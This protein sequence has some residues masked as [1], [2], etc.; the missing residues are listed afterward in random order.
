MFC[1]VERIN[2]Q[3]GIH[4]NPNVILTIVSLVSPCVDGSLSVIIDQYVV[5]SWGY[6]VVNINQYAINVSCTGSDSLTSLV[7]Y[8]PELAHSITS[9]NIQSLGSDLYTFP[10]WAYPVSG[11]RPFTIFG[12]QIVGIANFT[13]KAYTTAGGLKYQA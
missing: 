10:F 5:F 12:Y 6:P 11:T 7:L 4:K 3:S 2:N 13:V 1:F 8:S 9:W